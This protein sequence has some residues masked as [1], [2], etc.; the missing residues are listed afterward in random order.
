MWKWDQG[1]MQYF[2]YD[3]LRTMA[4]FIVEYDFKNTDPSFIRQA[5]KLDFSAPRT[6]SPWRNYSRIF[7]LCLL[8]YESEGIAI[9]TDAAKI[10]SLKFP[11]VCG[12]WYGLVNVGK[13]FP[14]IVLGG[15]AFVGA[16]SRSLT[17]SW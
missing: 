4:S 16:G 10:L 15:F 12:R 7:K 17:L 13:L 3:I 2:Q 1:R 8:V 14:S 5:T 6:H 11:N 9:P